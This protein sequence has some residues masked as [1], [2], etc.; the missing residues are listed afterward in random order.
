MPKNIALTSHRAE[1]LLQRARAQGM[2]EGQQRPLGSLWRRLA[3]RLLDMF[4]TFFLTFALVLLVFVWFLDGLSETL[5]PAPWGR[6]FVALLLYIIVSTAYEVVF[7]SQRGQTPGKDVMKLKVIHDASGTHP[8]VNV[9]LVRS[10]PLALL[11]LVPGA[12]IGTLATFVVGASA[13]VAHRKRA[14]HDLLAGTSVVVYD[15]DEEEDGPGRYPARARVSRSYGPRTWWHAIG[16]HL[17]RRADDRDPTM[18]G[19]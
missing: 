13:P 5:D 11:R 9:A 12:G 16:D 19:G 6:G 10:L 1:P 2:A 17:D 3:A 7:V 18:D 15:S 4:T 8:T 14:L